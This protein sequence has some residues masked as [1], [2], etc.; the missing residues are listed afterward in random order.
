MK[1]RPLF[2]LLLFIVSTGILV[3]IYYAAT[4]GKEAPQSPPW[5]ETLSD[6]NTCSRLKHV[7]SMQYDHFAD[8]AGKEQ[9]RSVAQLFRA[10][11]FA[12]RVQE[13]NCA[14]A[15]VRLGGSYSPPSKVVIFSGTTDSNLQRSIAYERQMLQAERR[16]D[17]DRAIAKSN[18]Y[19]ARMLIWA[20]AGDLQH[21]LLMERCRD[22]KTLANAP[23]ASYLVCPI[24]GNVYAASSADSYC[25]FCMADRRKF[26]RFE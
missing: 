1:L 16:A 22:A 15:I 14:N 18:R 9:Q 6:L 20:A 25:P 12:E 8:I 17:I 2:I 21:L 3:W 19:A 10:M 4:H 23:E 13:S 5:V 24:C 26:I 11:A 7:K